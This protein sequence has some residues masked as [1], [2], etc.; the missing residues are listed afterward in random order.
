MILAILICVGMGL[1]SCKKESDF[2]V[3]E[4]IQD[5]YS[6][7]ISKDVKKITI[8]SHYKGLPISMI[9]EWGFYNYDIEEITI[10][11]T[12]KKIGDFA[13]N[14]NYSLII[15]YDGTKEE[16]ENIEKGIN[17]RMNHMKINYKK[18]NHQENK[19]KLEFNQYLFYATL[20]DNTST[21][22]L[23]E[24]LKEAPL[25]I[26]MEDY[27]NFEKVGN[28]GFSL[29][30]N[31]EQITTTFGDLILYQGNALTIYYDTNT[32]NFTRLGRIDGVKKKELKEALGKGNV[33]VTLSLV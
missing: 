3:F 8:P 33:I 4:K 30:R 1:A 26:E 22:A 6:V 17:W 16:F 2:F 31:D 28:L 7:S 24:K 18:E 15:N 11:S 32:W 25:V 27:G 12:I 20:V 14:D 19:I 10:P 29:P 9:K 5:G 21:S 23:I 13:F